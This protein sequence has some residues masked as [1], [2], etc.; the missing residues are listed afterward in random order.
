MLTYLNLIDTEEG[1]NKF[2]QIYL[3]YRYTLLYV[4]KSIVKDHQLAEDIV[5]ETFLKIIEKIDDID[6]ISCSKTK[7][8]FVT[9]VRNKSKDVLR[10]IKREEN[11]PLEDI[12]Y[13]LEDDTP[14]PVDEIISQDGYR[15]L[16][17][18]IG[19]LDEKYRAV[20]ELK[21]IQGYS[22]KEIADILDITP[23]NV[24]VRTF[25]ARKMIIKMIE[26]SVEYDKYSS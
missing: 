10:K 6:D 26:G 9:I 13:S 12:E 22:D 23:K 15:K 11:I 24:N 17:E 8:F 4:A 1:K 16:V 2:E 5:H 7:S 18:Y 21:Y 14:I 3:K 20:L 25:R 19:Q